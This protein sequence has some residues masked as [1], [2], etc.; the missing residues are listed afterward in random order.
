M[1]FLV[2]NMKT[3]PLRKKS[4]KKKLLT[5]GSFYHRPG[6]RQVIIQTG[7]ACSNID[8]DKVGKMYSMFIT[9]QVIF[10]EIFQIYWF[11]DTTVWIYDLA[12]H[13]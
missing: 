10:S 8:E 1:S 7:I 9:S 12:Q 5:Q 11:S 3:V 13:I 6:K 2:L 4:K